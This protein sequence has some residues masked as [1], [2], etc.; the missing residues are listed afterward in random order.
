MNSNIEIF[1]LLCIFIPLASIQGYWIFND[2]K[3]RKI[4]GYW[5]WGIYGLMNIP[6]SL[7]IY[8]IFSRKILKKYKNK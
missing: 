5:I 6:T 8:L 1:L 4:K 3:K 7:I 2:A